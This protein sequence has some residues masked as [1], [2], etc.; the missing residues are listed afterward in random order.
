VTFAL[1]GG[2]DGAKFAISPHGVLSFT[3][4][5]NYETPTDAS[6]DNSYLVMIQAN[7]GN[8]GTA[9]QTITVMVLPINDNRPVITSADAVNVPENT[10]AVLTVT[11][12]DADLPP[13][14]LSFSIAGGEDQSKLNITPSGILSFNT[15]PD[16]DSP[17]DSNGDNVYIVIVQASDGSLPGVQAILVT[18]TNTNE[19]PLAGDYNNSGTVDLADY[20]AWRNAL[21]QSVTLPNDS[22]PGTVTQ[23]DYNIWRANFGRSAPL[24]ASTTALATPR[25]VPVRD[26]G[27]GSESVS[28]Q[29]RV[30]P[31]FSPGWLERVSNQ[32]IIETRM[33]AITSRPVQ[34][35]E[36]AS[37]VMS[38]PLHDHTPRK[39][40]ARPNGREAFLPPHSRD[41]ALVAWL[42]S[43]GTRPHRA[44]AANDAFNPVQ[45]PADCLPPSCIPIDSLDMAFSML[46][47]ALK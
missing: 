20:V 29:V 21:D 23:E 12:T 16:F 26:R 34:I 15:P 13:E 25:P 24:S 22:T 17:T 37:S 30:S 27:K 47:V 41:E 32:P 33:E 35:V 18:V 36:A 39:L 9:T 46:G 6:S 14:A 42:E 31:N 5:P 28:T 44:F 19:V 3:A 38:A 7:D 45:S 11:A 1:A 4:P 8:G 10:S 2:A 40:R 43:R